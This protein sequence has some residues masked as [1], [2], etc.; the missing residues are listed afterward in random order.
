MLTAGPR[1]PFSLMHGGPRKAGHLASPQPLLRSD[2]LPSQNMINMLLNKVRTERSAEQSNSLEP[3][4]GEGQ[5]PQQQ[6]QQPQQQQQQQ[7]P[8]MPPMEGGG[9]PTI[10]AP[11]APMAT[12]SS[13][14]VPTPGPMARSAPEVHIPTPTATIAPNS[15][16]P[17]TPTM[18]AGNAVNMMDNGKLFMVGEEG[19]KPPVKAGSRAKA[20]ARPRARASANNNNQPA[21][22]NSIPT[23]MSQI[24]PPPLS[25]SAASMTAALLNSTSPPHNQGVLLSAGASLNS[26]AVDE[27]TL[28]LEARK[29]KKEENVMK[30]EGE[31]E[32]E[33]TEATPSATPGGRRRARKPRAPRAATTTTPTAKVRTQRAGTTQ[34]TKRPFTRTTAAGTT[35]DGAGSGEEKDTNEDGSDRRDTR[36]EKKTNE[37]VVVEGTGVLGEMKPR[38]KRRAAAGTGARRAAAGTGARPRAAARPR[39]VRPTVTKEPK[40]PRAKTARARGGRGASARG[41]KGLNIVRNM[42]VAIIP[43]MAKAFFAFLRNRER[44]RLNRLVTDD[45]QQI[46]DGVEGEGVQTVQQTK[47]KF[48]TRRFTNVYRRNDATTVEFMKILAHAV[49]EYRGNNPD[50]PEDR[51]LGYVIFTLGAWR[52]FGTPMFAKEC[53]FLSDWNDGEKQRLRSIV[54][55]YI[56]MEAVP[57]ICTAAYKPGNMMRFNLVRKPPH[58]KDFDQCVDG[59]LDDLWKICFDIPKIGR[60]TGLWEEVAKKISE[61]RYF[62]EGI[63]KN[64]CPSFHAKEL[65]QDLLD[66]RIFGGRDAVIDLNTW[67]AVGP[68]AKRGLN[69]LTGRIKP[70][71]DI[72]NLFQKQAVFEMK[73]LY[74]MC[75]DKFYYNWNGKPTLVGGSKPPPLELHDVQFGLCEFDKFMRAVNTNPYIKDDW[76]RGR[77]KFFHYTDEQVQ[78]SWLFDLSEYKELIEKRK[79]QRE[80]A[81]HEEIERDKLFRKKLETHRMMLKMKILGEGKTIPTRAT[82]PFI[83]NRDRARPSRP[84]IRRVKALQPARTITR[85]APGGDDCGGSDDEGASSGSNCRP[86]RPAFARRRKAAT[87]AGGAQTSRA[88]RPR[89]TKTQGAAASNRAPGQA[90]IE[91][92]HDDED[93]N[94]VV[95]KGPLQNRRKTINTEANKEVAAFQRSDRRLQP[96]KSNGQTPKVEVKEEPHAPPPEKKK[97]IE[98]MNCSVDDVAKPLEEPRKVKDED[99]VKVPKEE[100]KEDVSP[101]PRRAKK[102]PR[103]DGIKDNLGSPRIKDEKLRIPTTTPPESGLRKKRPS[104]SVILETETSTSKLLRRHETKTDGDDRHAYRDRDAHNASRRYDTAFDGPR[105]PLIGRHRLSSPSRTED[106]YGPPGGGDCDPHSPITASS[107]PMMRQAVSS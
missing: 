18:K 41:K 86:Q 73:T 11:N 24:T 55:D 75:M 98:W 14:S 99:K 20:K 63:G 46:Y 38:P 59:R 61:A 53:G 62:G 9:P 65:A 102:T 56:D 25:V 8:T 3:S 6:Q 105:S 64:R 83:L 29:K 37:G 90:P 49:D 33:E 10:P 51:V 68:G 66:T 22:P 44:I 35:Q 52:A 7:Q 28:R 15:G 82:V 77:T 12:I 32:D 4:T 58:W 5:Q 40:E 21:L 36:Q 19:T 16:A 34:A 39:A 45:P 92:V 101:P 74:T 71:T 42:E 13:N 81:Y 106:A 95:T 79:K 84:P 23:S 27:R 89:L 80:K 43:F 1:S 70:P 47:Q 103:L 72:S 104:S 96:V 26:G 48:M 76:R 17:T 85:A 31:E 60:E 97:T 69:W 87:T 88:K 78:N 100:N 91:V 67:C 2:V 94:D 93:D 30:N 54:Q 107:S 50:E 57:L